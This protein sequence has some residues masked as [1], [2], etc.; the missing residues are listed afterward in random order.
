MIKLHGKIGLL[1]L[2]ISNCT[3]T[4]NSSCVR[5]SFVYDCGGI[6]GLGEP[7]KCTFAGCSRPSAH[8]S[9]VATGESMSVQAMSWVIEHSKHKGNAF[10]VLLMVAN[11]ARSDGSGAWPSVRTLAREARIS[12]RAVQYTVRRLERSGELG[13]K[14]GC[15][16]GGSNLYSLPK[17]AE[18]AY[19]NL[20]PPAQHDCAPPTQILAPPPAIALT[21]EPS[22]KQPSINRYLEARKL[23]HQMPESFR[24]TE[25]HKNLAEKLHIDLAAEFEQFSDFHNSKGAR[26]KDWNL[27]LNTWLRNAPKF[28]RSNSQTETLAERNKRALAQVFG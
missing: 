22:L 25:Y 20:A 19:A 11:H 24:P 15:G 14:V 16:P 18:S 23:A 26:F 21:P 9:F 5:R 3:T 4:E 28:K 12:P 10:V 7:V 27:A 8:G 2:W 13:T 1:D 17:Y 6:V